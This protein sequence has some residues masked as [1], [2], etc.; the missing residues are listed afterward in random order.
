V[1]EVRAFRFARPAPGG[2]H[3]GLRR[4]VHAP[5]HGADGGT[6][7][8]SEGR[9]ETGLCRVEQEVDVV[10]LEA[11]ESGR[12]GSAHAGAGKGRVEVKYQGG[13]RYRFTPW[14]IHHRDRPLGQAGK[15]LTR[16]IREHATR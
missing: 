14:R 7:L 6:V 1:I 9:G 15:A 10:L 3:E 4:I 12:P 13:S 16:L 5:A 11:K 2:F 8:R